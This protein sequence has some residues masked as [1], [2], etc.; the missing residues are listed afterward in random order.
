[1]EYREPPRTAT[2]QARLDGMIGDPDSRPRF[3]RFE[4]RGNERQLDLPRVLIAILTAMGTVALIA[5]LGLQ[6]ARSAV[7]WL[8]QQ[9]LYQVRFQDIRLR[10]EPPSWF[11]GGTE[12]F[13]RQVRERS[14]EAEVLSVLDLNPGRLKR[15]FKESPWV[16]EVVRIEYPPQG[17][18]VDLVYK[19]PVATHSS[20]PGAEVILDRNGHILPAEDIDTNELGPLIK[21][22][23][24]LLQASTENRSGGIWK[25][26]APGAEATRLE[27]CIREAA[28]LA[29]FFQ[30]PERAGD[31]SSTPALHI[32]SIF[33]TDPRGLFVQTAEGVMILWGETPAKEPAGS[34][35]SQ[36]KWEI[37]K[38]WAGS[39]SRRELLPGGYW[40]F[41]RSDLRPVEPKSG[42]A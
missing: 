41:T 22:T 36:E 31:R 42:H 35:T 24:K 2:S 30:E 27:H 10:Q 8:H 3:R 32:L 39:N 7:R 23:G 19:R 33:A 5:Y 28:S 1:M 18:V 16:E 9:P 37:L 13:L 14:K 34:L 15:D 12:T 38:K 25:S 40:T 29:G 21:I 6:A 11:R 17:I 26:G 4:F 20:A